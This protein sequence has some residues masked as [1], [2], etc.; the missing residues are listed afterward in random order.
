[1][2]TVSLWVTTPRRT[3]DWVLTAT[4]LIADPLMVFW[5]VSLIENGNAVYGAVLALVGA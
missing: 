4:A 1:M 5:G 3:R 2:T